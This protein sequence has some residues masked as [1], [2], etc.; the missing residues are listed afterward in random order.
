M[1]R[2]A[3]SSKNQLTSEFETTFQIFPLNRDAKR[4]QELT[5]ESNR[6]SFRRLFL[7]RNAIPPTDWRRKERKRKRRKEKEI[8]EKFMIYRATVLFSHHFSLFLSREFPCVS[9][10]HRFPGQLTRFE[11]GRTR[12]RWKFSC[13]GEIK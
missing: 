5:G 6:P 2:C 3:A 4:V 11:S 10:V 7:N 1:I 13:K 12:L 8:D 9:L